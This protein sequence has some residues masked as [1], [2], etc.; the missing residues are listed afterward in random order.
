MASIS[1]AILGGTSVVLGKAWSCDAALQIAAIWSSCKVV[2][3]ASCAG[4][5]D[6]S[7]CVRYCKKVG[8][9]E[10]LGGYSFSK[11]LDLFPYVD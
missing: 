1:D 8:R 4:V 7:G 2:H 6:V 3:V 10:H 11:I 5:I 9:D